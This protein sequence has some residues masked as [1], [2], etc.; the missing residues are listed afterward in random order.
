MEVLTQQPSVFLTSTPFT[1][2]ALSS[3]IC[4]SPVSKPPPL[5][6]PPGHRLPPRSHCFRHSSLLTSC[7]NYPAY[8][9]PISSNSHP[10]SFCMSSHFVS[11]VSPR[12]LGRTMEASTDFTWGLQWRVCTREFKSQWL[13]S[14]HSKI[15]PGKPGMYIL[16]TIPV[17]AIVTHTGPPEV[18]GP[19]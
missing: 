18:R 12:S 11:D 10:W 1:F 6:H 17:H 8:I 14:S 13:L 5:G 19:I 4:K 3:Q 7:G 16:V 15:R 2:S 9:L